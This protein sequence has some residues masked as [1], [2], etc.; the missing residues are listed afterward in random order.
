MKNIINRIFLER[1]DLEILVYYHK[2]HLSYHRLVWE[3]VVKSLTVGVDEK[4]R[5]MN[6][7][8][9]TVGDFFV[10]LHIPPSLAMWM[11]K[12]LVVAPSGRDVHGMA[13]LS[14]S[15]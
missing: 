11:G 3:D 9:V 12:A 6:N 14:K 10:I 2:K 7:G 15:L 8:D 5:S 1:I 13:R 4:I